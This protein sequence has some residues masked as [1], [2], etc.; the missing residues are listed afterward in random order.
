MR[1]PRRIGTRKSARV[2]PRSAPVLRS[3]LGR[4]IVIEA[5]SWGSPWGATDGR[6]LA[7]GFTRTRRRGRSRSGPR[8]GP[9]RRPRASRARRPRTNATATVGH[10]TRVATSG[11]PPART[12]I[13]APTSSP[14]TT[15]TSAPASPTTPASTT[16]ERQTWRGVIP[17]AR[18]MP[19]SRTRSM[20][21]IVSVLAMP[22]AATMTAMTASAS[23]RPKTR[24]SASSMAPGTRSRVTTSRADWRGRLGEVVA[25]RGRGAR[26]RSGRRTRPRRHAEAVRRVVPADEHR[27]AAA[28]GQRALGD[29]DD[30]QRQRGPVDRGRV[31]RVAEPDAEALRDCGRH[32]RGA[33]R[34]ERGERRLPVARRSASVARPRR[35]PPRPSPRRRSATPSIA[36][37]N[38]AIGLTRA[39]PVIAS[40]SSATPSSGGDRPDRGDEHVARARRPRSSCRPRRGRPG[41]PRRA[42][43]PASGRP[44]APRSSASRGPG[45]AAATRGRAAPRA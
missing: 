45:R 43:R 20:T 2:M 10:G 34:V 21:F 23:N 5:P 3:S 13:N 25:G 22:S 18:R 29:P 44:P 36:R 24:S 35:G 33:A 12:T 16:T 41:R 32:D 6:S 11:V 9:D 19:I 27:L 1:S 40:S 7:S 14:V 17:A 39:T 8:G 4:A 38:V 15:P 26:V 37:S 31:Q 30:A 42:R 28:A